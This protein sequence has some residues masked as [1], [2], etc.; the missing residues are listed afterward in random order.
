MYGIT[1]DCRLKDAVKTS[2]E[3][4]DILEYPS[5]KAILDEIMEKAREEKIPDGV[6]VLAA[7]SAASAGAAGSAAVGDA[8]D[9]ADANTPESKFEALPNK[10]SWM[11]HIE[12]TIKAHIHFVVDQKSTSLLATALK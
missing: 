11:K 3:V 6:T 4:A 12:P 1:F 7:D 8:G 5:I 9:V 10:E 2:L